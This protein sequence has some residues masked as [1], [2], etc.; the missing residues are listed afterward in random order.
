MAE[1]G[2]LLGFQKARRVDCS[3]WAEAGGRK[4]IKA[5]RAGEA[6]VQEVR[7]LVQAQ[8]GERC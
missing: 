2:D 6:L 1:M 3:P 5:S 4:D 8:S 7:L